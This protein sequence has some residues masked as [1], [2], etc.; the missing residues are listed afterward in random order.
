MSYQIT[1]AFV[2]QFGSNL[3]LLS[4]QMGSKLRN[5]VD[6]ET[7]K[8]EQAFFDQLGPTEARL[9]T[10]RHADSPVVST[11]HDR[12]RVTMGNYDWGDLIDGVDK[13]RTLIDP[14]SGYSKNGSFALGRA[15]DD[16]VIEALGG[17]A[18][19]GQRGATAVPLPNG[20]KV[21][22]NLGGSNIGLT[23][24]KL[25]AAK[26]KFGKNDVDYNEGDLVMVVTQQQLDDLLAID[27]VTSADYNT[28]RALVRGEIDTFMGFRFVR[29]QR[30]ILD[31]ASDV[32][33]CYAFIKDG[34]RIGLGQDIVSRVTERA[35]KCFS[36]YAYASMTLGATRMEEKKVVEIAC[37]ESP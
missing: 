16:V 26:S 37:D 4:Q 6:S 13:I 31:V 15:M 8:G 36:W 23:L 12:R 28:V 32:R 19:T 30:L 1:T 34:V 10:T 2:D 27:K 3:Q 25:I 35:D 20:Q 22:V 5:L 29:C 18:Y 11:P 21:A 24:A 7:V 9:R 33:M 14:E 17:T